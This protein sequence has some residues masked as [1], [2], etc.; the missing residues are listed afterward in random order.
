MKIPLYVFIY[1]VFTS[2]LLLVQIVLLWFV[3]A[4]A[5]IGFLLPG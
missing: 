3:Q 1:V 4:Y 5:R 2:K